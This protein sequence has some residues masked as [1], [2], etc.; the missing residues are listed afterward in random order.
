[1]AAPE[2]RQQRV[3]LKRKKKPKSF[4]QNARGMGKKGKFGHG[5][6]MDQETYDYYVR[7][8][9]RLNGEFESP[10]EKG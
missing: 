2:E 5:T 6:Q 10:E 3:P 9:E 4:L 8:L 7:I 1:M